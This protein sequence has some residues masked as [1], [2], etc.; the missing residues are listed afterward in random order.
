[1]ALPWWQHHKH[2]LGYYIILYYIILYYS[3]T[4]NVTLANGV[5][6]QRSSSI[7]TFHKKAQ[8]SPRGRA[9]LGVV[10][11]LAVTQG[12]WRHS[13]VW[14]KFLL[15]FRSNYVSMMCRYWNTQ[16]R[17]WNLGCGS[18]K[19]LEMASFDR[20]RTNFYWRSTV[21]MV[22]SCIISQRKRFVVENRDLFVTQP[23]LT[24]LLGGF[25]SEYWHIT[26]NT[27]NQNDGNTRR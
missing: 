17:T 18:F 7:A 2:C 19:V 13:R 23:Y 1:M 12:N 15:V 16:R 27:E 22:L 6:C 5:G 9:T 21:T 8:L 26:F 25:L 10:E 3:I 14:G 24:P 4:Y 11:N 20:L